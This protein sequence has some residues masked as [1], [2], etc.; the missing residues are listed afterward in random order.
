MKNMRTIFPLIFI[1]GILCFISINALLSKAHTQQV[2]TLQTLLVQE[3]E[4]HFSTIKQLKIWHEKFGGVF[5]PSTSSDQYHFEIFSLTPKN[6]FNRAHGFAEDALNVFEKMA[7]QKSY[8]RFSEDQLDFDYMG[9]LYVEKR[10]LQCHTNYKLGDVRGGVKI[11][12]PLINYQDSIHS[13]NKQ[14]HSWS[15]LVGLSILAIT[16]LLIFFLSRLL[17]QKAAISRLNDSLEIKVAERTQEVNQLYSREHYLKDLL[18]NLSEINEALISSYSVS[19]IIR[20]SVEKLNNHPN[21]QLML[22]SQFDGKNLHIRELFGDQYELLTDQDLSLEQIQS[23]PLL[24]SLFNTLIY[25]HWQVD[26]DVNFD[27]FVTTRNRVDDYSLYA[28]ISLP[29]MEQESDTEFSVLTLWTDRKEGFDQEEI[30]I[31]DSVAKDIAMALSAF[32]QRQLSERLKQEQITNYEETILAFVDMIEQRDAYTAGHTLRVAKYSR[33]MA[34]KLELKEPLIQKL[35]KA[36]ILHD[37]GKIATP[38]TILLKPGKLSRIEYDLI[39]QHVTA[40]YKMLSKVKMYEELAEIIKFH[41]EH[42]DGSGYPYGIQGEEIPFEAHILIV[43]DAFDAMTTNRI[44]KP[45]LSVKVALNELSKLK[46]KQFHP[47]V[48]SAALTCLS[49]VEISQTT[50]LP[51]TDLESQRFSYFFTDSLTG[52]YNLAYLRLVLNQRS[53]SQYVTTVKLSKFSAF[54]RKFGWQKGDEVLA[55]IAAQMKS[56]FPNE[57]IFRYEGDDFLII[58]QEFIELSEGDFDISLEDS[59]AVISIKCSSYKWDVAVE[60]DE[61]LPDLALDINSH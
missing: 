2:S 24:K 25:K 35:E 44:Y 17:H 41:H 57:K 56:L 21:Y 6:H 43:A 12:I 50:Q 20:A 1:V 9:A 42:Y 27:H 31:L 51:K 23:M 29:V 48:V 39:K 26:N 61:L 46:G 18:G 37:I 22:L 47:D 33:L 10:C 36:A 59:D 54:N 32:K 53:S 49:D 14:Y 60:L 58:T 52:L 4:A 15:L 28:S 8:Y 5:K 13:L 45:R 38:D 7:P 3:A 11:S 55:S 40:G 16:L 19:S 30:Q 34:E